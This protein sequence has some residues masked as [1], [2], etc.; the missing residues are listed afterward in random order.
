MKRKKADIKITMISR[1]KTKPRMRKQE[2]LDNQ[3]NS[4]T[5]RTRKQ[6]ANNEADSKSLV[7]KPNHISLSAD[8]KLRTLIEEPLQGK[9]ISKV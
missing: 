6:N 3:E 7:T 8:P 9:P 2:L 4:K 5:Q 1:T